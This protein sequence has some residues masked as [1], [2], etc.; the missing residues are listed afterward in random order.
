[1]AFYLQSPSL[2]EAMGLWQ[3]HHSRMSNEGFPDPQKCYFNP[4][5]SV[6]QLLVRYA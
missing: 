4:L 6:L 1:M 2:K 3:S 5:L